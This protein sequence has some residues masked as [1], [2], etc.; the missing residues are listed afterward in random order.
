MKKARIQPRGEAGFSL[1]E[2][3]VV[4]GIVAV[5]AAMS[6]PSYLNAVYQ[7]ERSAL[8]AECRTLHTALMNYNADNGFFPA[9]A[10]FNLQTLAPLTDEGYFKMSD[11]LIS[12]LEGQSLML[13][14]APD[15]GTVD[16]EFLIVMRAN[17]NPD[18]V[19][20]V[21]HTG[22][23]ESQGFLDGVYMITSEEFESAGL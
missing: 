20:I 11:S 23:V 9:A 4:M 1:L 19:A 3:L 7:S 18:L 8:L 13:Y 22:L 5:L 14:L 12:K 2:L 17:I 21:A 6:I 10:S 15:E 16:S